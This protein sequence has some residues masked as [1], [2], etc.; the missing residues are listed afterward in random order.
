[1]CAS[2]SKLGEFQEW[3]ALRLPGSETVDMTAL[4]GR[5]GGS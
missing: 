1:M 5:L 4:V 2:R 3:V